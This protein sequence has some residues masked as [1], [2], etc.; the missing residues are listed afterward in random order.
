METNK[1]L[2]NAPGTKDVSGVELQIKQEIIAKIRSCFET[3]DAIELDTPILEL[4]G[5]I[6]KLYGE[7]F[8]KQVYEIVDYNEKD[9]SNKQF[10]RYDLTLPLARYC[11]MKGLKT[12]RR[13]QI[14][15]V[16]RRDNPNVKYGRLRE[17]YQCDFDIVSMDNNLLYSELEIL[18]LLVR[19]LN[20]LIGDNSYTIRFNNKQLLIDLITSFGIKV[21]NINIIIAALDKKDKYSWE[22]IYLELEKNGENCQIVRKIQEIF[23]IIEPLPIDQTLDILQ[24]LVNTDSLRL[25]INK[26]QAL[27][28][29][30]FFTFDLLLARGLDYYTGLIFEAE[31]LNKNIMPSSIAAGGRYDNMIGKLGGNRREENIGSIGLSIGVERIYTIL[32]TQNIIPISRPKILVASIGSKEDVLLAKLKL[33][34]ELRSLGLNIIISNK[35]KLKPQLTFALEKEAKYM[36]IIGDSELLSQTFKIK[37]LKEKTEIVVDKKAAIEFLLNNCPPSS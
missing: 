37:D 13:Y 36:I 8:K 19:I 14:G 34:F 18:E 15:K 7:E 26:L 27:D 11:A 17:F 31:Y 25:L 3:M 6:D 9:L 5:M 35:T 2:R 28:L 30:K 33:S 20:R 12:I 24:P 4:R 23:N 21:N 29:Y 16:Y 32:N 10:L 1:I 22:E